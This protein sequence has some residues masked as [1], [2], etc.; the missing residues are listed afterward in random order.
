MRKL[1]LS[2]FALCASAMYAVELPGFTIYQADGS[3]TGFLAEEIDSIY[4]KEAISV[5]TAYNIANS[6]DI[7]EMTEELY[8]IEG[9]VS[10]PNYSEQ[11]KNVTFNL[12]GDNSSTIESYRAEG[13]IAATIKEGD[14]VRVYGKLQNYRGTTP[15]IY[16]G[17]VMNATENPLNISVI[18]ISNDNNE[19]KYELSSLQE[20]RHD[21]N[22]M[23]LVKENDSINISNIRK[24]EFEIVAQINSAV[25]ELDE[26]TL[27]VYP[28]PVTK[29]LTVDGVDLGNTLTIYD[30]QGR[31]LMQ[32][33]GNQIDVSTLTQG[34]YLLKVE[35]STIKFVKK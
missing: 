27:F 29:T 15:E 8:L 34:N 33:I 9:I 31:I 1:F 11:Y 26:N 13:D 17:T 12:N 7:N 10:S 22:G 2:F 21:E 14:V 3:K 19:T 23:V 28:N 5:T 6:L 18:A 4:F 24:L 32:T 16:R 25:T 20:I 35:N 30:L